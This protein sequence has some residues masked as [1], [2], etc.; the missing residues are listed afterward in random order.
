M[1]IAI[2]G[3]GKIGAH[4]A[5]VLS[6]EGHDVTLIDKDPIQLEKVSR[7]IDVSA[8]HAEAP[9]WRLFE[10]LGKGAPHLFFAATQNDETNL[11]AC[12][13]AKQAGF[14]KTVARLKSREYL[15]QRR[16]DFRQLFFVDHFI[17]PDL[18]AAH[19][20]LNMLIFTGDRAVHQ[21]AHGAIQM[22]TLEIPLS[23]RGRGETLQEWN[24]PQDLVVGLIRRKGQPPIFP[25]GQDVLVPGD[26]VTVVG[27][28]EAMQELHE[29]LGIPE[30]K[31]RSAV[32]I[33]GTGIGLHLTH[34]LL[35]Q[36]VSVRL[37]ESE[38]G[39]AV[40]LAE[41]LPRAT[42]LNCNPADA[43][44]LRAEQIGEA[45]AVVAC[46]EDE[47]HN[48]LVAALCHQL[49]APRSFALFTDPA[50]A[51]ILEKTG[52]TPALSAKGSLANRLVSIL[53]QETLISIASL[54]NDEVKIIELK[55]AP[56]SK[57]VGIPLSALGGA[58]P[59]QLLIAA[60]ESGGQVVIGRG[61]RILAPHDT[62]VVICHANQVPE[63]PR[64]F[65]A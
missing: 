37:I 64:L 27:R 23:W 3:A 44:F 9:N 24:L 56:A 46:G 60:I 2:L 61:N 53:H 49:G 29:L 34:L 36:G 51:P 45:G 32:V 4:A 1:K 50:L 63:L 40:A 38:P 57:L 48:L 41:Q 11:V 59:Q 26:E 62:V 19:D 16:I 10:E 55:V 42:I 28:A 17:S 5:A 6:Q 54:A 20:L 7:E 15:Q 43:A 31:L 8:L 30:E 35:Q 47:G 21:F 65:H 14:Q 33:G 12:A 39:R 18:L 58:L 22:R 52:V 25:R 13:V